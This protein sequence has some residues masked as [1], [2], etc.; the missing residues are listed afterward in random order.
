M[1]PPATEGAAADNCRTSCD[2]A[3]IK[4]ELAKVEEREVTLRVTDEEKRKA[5]GHSKGMF[6]SSYDV[7]QRFCFE[8]KLIKT[9]YRVETVT[10]QGSGK[11]I[12]ANILDIGPK[13]ASITWD[14]L[15]FLS[16]LAVEIS[17]PIERIAKMLGKFS[18]RQIFN[19][20]SMA[21]KQ[22]LPIYLYLAE[23]LA[24]ARRLMVDD[25]V[26][27]V[28]E[29][30]RKLEMGIYGKEN[31]EQLHALVAKTAEKLGRAHLTANGKSIKK[32]FNVSC[33]HG[34]SD[35]LERESYIVFF[36]SHN[37]SSGNL[38]SQILALRRR[39]NKNVYI[40]GD[41]SSSNRPLA[42]Y[43]QL[44]NI[45]MI[46]CGAHARRPFWRY[47]ADDDELC[48]FM[49]R[50]FLYLSHIEKILSCKDSRREV[51]LKYRRKYARKIWQAIHRR[52]LSVTK[53]KSVKKNKGLKFWPPN[54]DLHAACTYIVNN[55]VE[56]TRYI[57]NPELSFTNNMTERL[58]R[59]EK[60]LLVSC[61]F[62]FSEHGRVVFDILRTIMM[63]CRTISVKFSDYLKWLGQHDDD[64]INFNPQL[65]TPR[66]FLR[67]QTEQKRK[68]A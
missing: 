55:F 11:S 47:R 8:L 28:I 13:G 66:E 27:K 29:A 17:L 56:L 26:T 22:L 58:L 65:Y 49:L 37:G 19:W 2:E 43:Y 6:H 51:I 59:A 44:F 57:D 20:L 38:L 12:R 23:E 24:E 25:S 63:T 61:K 52:A 39:A 30:R 18:D 54:S 7:A 50:G 3:L 4:T 34:Q 31:P 46:G 67:H 16:H 9:K 14:A 33:I 68:S 64:E 5:F 35:P 32:Q 40:Q 53:A 10:D 1:Q 62:R 45:V 41:L 21:A 60:I 15:S 42:L 36:R 48:D